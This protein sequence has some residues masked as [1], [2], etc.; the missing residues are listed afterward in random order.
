MFYCQ[1]VWIPFHSF[2]VVYNANL[3]Y[4]LIWWSLCKCHSNDNRLFHS[5]NI[6]QFI[7]EFIYIVWVFVVNNQYTCACI[8]DNLL[9]QCLTN[10]IWCFMSSNSRGHKSTMSSYDTLSPMKETPLSRY[11]YRLW[12]RIKHIHD[13]YL[14]AAY[15]YKPACFLI[16]P[17][18]FHA[19]ISHIQPRVYNTFSDFSNIIAVCNQSV[20]AY[21]AITLS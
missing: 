12:Y 11:G 6:P 4:K 9:Q 2:P 5:L 8:Q 15:A 18:S 16:L 3:D 19:I 17:F 14:V 20:A 10:W 1:L 21:L 13:H 7:A